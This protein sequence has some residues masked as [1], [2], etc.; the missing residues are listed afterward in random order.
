LGTILKIGEVRAN[1]LPRRVQIKNGIL[2]IDARQFLQSIFQT[3]DVRADAWVSHTHLAIGRRK[4][5]HI[6]YEVSFL[7][8]FVQIRHT[9]AQHSS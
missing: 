4:K 5:N 6:D 2:A 7:S 9:T 1:S 8:I 3:D